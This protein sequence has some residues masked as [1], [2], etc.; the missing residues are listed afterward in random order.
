MILRKSML[1]F[2]AA[3]V[4]LKKMKTAKFKVLADIMHGSGRDLMRQILK[5]TDI[6]LTL[7]REDVN[8]GFDGSKPE[9][10]PECLAGNDV[11]HEKRKV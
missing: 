7:M 6:K 9:P 8:P 4:N 3:Y 10:I 1:N 2:S 11:P 5:G